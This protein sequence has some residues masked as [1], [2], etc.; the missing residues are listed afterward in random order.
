MIQASPHLAWR[1]KHASYTA[2]GAPAVKILSTIQEA[3]EGKHKARGYTDDDFDLAVTVMRLEGSRLA[4][5]AT[6]SKWAAE[7]VR[8]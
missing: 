3:I 8:C 1:K 4:L 6:S 5:R 7:R 2:E